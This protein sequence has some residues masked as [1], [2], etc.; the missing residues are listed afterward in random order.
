MRAPGLDVARHG[1][2]KYGQLVLVSSILVLD[3]YGA[4]KYGAGK[5]DDA[6]FY[7]SDS[8]SRFT[9]AWLVYNCPLYER[10]LLHVKFS[11][12]LEQTQ[13]LFFCST[14]SL[15]FPLFETIRNIFRQRTWYVSKHM[16]KFS[17]ISTYKQGI[18]S[19]QSAPMGE[20]TKL[21]LRANQKVPDD[22]AK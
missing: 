13:Y 6:R 2:S 1:G 5:K 10:R 14:L 18:I 20:K 4:D 7:F 15:K 8:L 16:N 21:A 12:R 9:G 3:K 17:I 22:R 11:N 19:S